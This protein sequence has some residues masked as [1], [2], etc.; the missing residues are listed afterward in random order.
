MGK[1]R[2]NYSEI[3]DEDII[4]VGGER[5]PE[6][7]LWAAILKNYL[8]DLSHRNKIYRERA[9]EDIKDSYLTGDLHRVCKMAAININS[10]LQQAYDRGFKL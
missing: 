8:Q 3:N 2:N 1:F 4:M 7:R 5:I 6:Q 9:I 10:F